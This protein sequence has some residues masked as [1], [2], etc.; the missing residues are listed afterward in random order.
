MMTEKYTVGVSLIECLSNQA[1]A[2]LEIS[3]DDL[4]LNTFTEETVLELDSSK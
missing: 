1:L 3:I 4:Y 2:A